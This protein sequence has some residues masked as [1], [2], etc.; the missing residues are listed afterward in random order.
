MHLY[1]LTDS[2]RNIW[3][4]VDN[5]DI[6]LSAIEMALTTLE[7]EIQSKAQNITVILRGMEND[8][9]VIKAEE[10][11]LADRRKALEN[12][13]AWF[14]NYL[15]EQMEVAGLDKIKTPTLTIAIQ[16]NP[17]AVQ[18]VNEKEIPAKFL[19]VVPEQYKPDLVKIREY[20]KNN[21]A[22]WAK[23]EQKK[24]LRVR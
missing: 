16:K 21:T 10:R 2:Y 8:A 14:K 5:E 13:V 1:D 19:T 9:E 4:L 18:I 7:S 15:M 11:R 20:L 12:K 3:N 23:L 6:D 17:P 24:S 22:G